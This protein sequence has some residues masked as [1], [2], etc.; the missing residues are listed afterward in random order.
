[1]GAGS[2][3]TCAWKAGLLIAVGAAGGGAALAVASV[4]G[5][6][7]AIN[8]CYG[9]QVRSGTTTPSTTGPN[10][11]IIDTAAGQ[12]CSTTSP[13]GGVPSEATL[14]WNAVGPRGPQGPRGKSVTIAAGHTLT[15]PGGGVVTVGSS[16]GVTVTT[17]TLT[18]HSKAIGTVEFG[19]GLKFPLYSY[20][21]AGKGTSG[22]GT[23]GKTNIH[24]LNFTK[25]VDKSSPTLFKYCAKGTHIP[26]VTIILRKGGG[27]AGQPQVYLKIKLQTVFISSYQQVNGGTK[28]SES[29]S[30]NFTKIQFKNVAQ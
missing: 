19:G 15:L 20:N 3:L 2:G 9:I 7:G 4:P 30:L 29:I 16:K 6:D 24:D 13:L 1:V 22:G 18:R 8:A 12:T 27:K 17:P 23:A 28:P 21:V 5:S 11:R 14:S 26:Q 25:Y 10:L